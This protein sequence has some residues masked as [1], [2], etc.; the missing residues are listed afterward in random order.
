M[1]FPIE[2]LSDE[3][4][5]LGMVLAVVIGIA[6]G[7]VLERAGFGRA[8]KLVG[9]FYGTDMTVLKVMFTAIVTTML[10]AVVLSGVGVFD[11]SEAQL[12]YPTYLW[13]MIVGGFVLGVGFALSGYCPGT[14]FVAAAS[15]KLDGLATVGGVALGS[16]LYAEVEPALGAFP[17]SGRLGSFPISSWMGIP[18]PVV[19]VLVVVVAIAA[20]LG[21]ERMEQLLGGRAAEPG[22]A[23]KLVFGTFIALAVLAV[24]TLALPSG[25][26]AAP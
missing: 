3:R 13:P 20:F 18:A 23:R 6:F 17:S 1:T 11:L 15:G 26:A 9:Q 21:A 19:A 5:A 24:A 10:G 14:S 25:T 8:E 7:F 4:R 22:P 12:N 16:I 2:S